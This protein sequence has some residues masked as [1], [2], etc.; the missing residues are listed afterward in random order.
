MLDTRINP[1]QTHKPK[2]FKIT[3]S[4]W[5]SGSHI[6]MRPDRPRARILKNFLSFLAL[7]YQELK[8]LPK[9]GSSSEDRLLLNSLGY[10]SAVTRSTEEAP[11][12]LSMTSRR[13][14]SETASDW[15]RMRHRSQGWIAR[16]PKAGTLRRN[17]R[18]R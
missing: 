12:I 3:N 13:R 11:P 9:V 14:S 8:P 17:P 5:A 10:V 7:E 18:L 4:R 1:N 16:G 15:S 6:R 2:N